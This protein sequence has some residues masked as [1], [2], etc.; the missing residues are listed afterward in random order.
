MAA[1]LATC[2]NKEQR[3]VI[4][5]F[6]SEGVKPIE[7]HRWMKV[8][9]GDA[10][11]LL[12]QVYKWTRKFMNG[13]S[14]VTDSLQ[15][16]QAHRERL[17]W[18]SFGMNEGYLGALHAQVEHCEQFNICRSH[19]ESSASCNQVQM[20]QTSEYRCFVATWQCSAPYCPFNCCDNSR[21]VLRVS[22]I[23][24]VLARP[25][26]QWLSC[27]WTAQRGDGRQVFQVRQKQAVHD[28]PRC[29]PK[30]FFSRG[31]HALLKCWNTCMVC[32]GDYVEKR[33]HCVLNKLRDK[34]YLRFS[35][36]SPTYHNSSGH[37]ITWIHIV[38]FGN[39]KRK[40]QR[41]THV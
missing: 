13:T 10:C 21:S 23:S 16:G 31:I 26:P 37:R 39:W 8:Q 14:S 4:H 28:W 20:M 29:Q 24:A 7:I 19:E 1:L 12:Q 17:C 2:T 18:L 38:N 34:K 9:Y 3:S 6:S 27:L 5:F 36:D 30:D 33:S 25:R 15:H 32:N 35:F 22:S 11:L 40:L 41:A